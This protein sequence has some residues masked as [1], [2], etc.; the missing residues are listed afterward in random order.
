M[1][2]VIVSR[3]TGRSR[4]SRL[5][6]DRVVVSTS[7]AVSPILS[8]IVPSLLSLWP[9][10]GATLASRHGSLVVEKPPL[11]VKSSSEACQPAVSTDDPVTW[12]HNRK[13]VSTVR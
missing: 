5:R 8:L 4:S 6:T 1:Q 13:R 11:C 12:K 10:T 3:A 9:L 7:S 2:S